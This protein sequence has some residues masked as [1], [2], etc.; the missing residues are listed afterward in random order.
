M[1]GKYV[2]NHDPPVNACSALGCLYGLY[3]IGV[4]WIGD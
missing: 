2:F 3:E 1:G 4:S